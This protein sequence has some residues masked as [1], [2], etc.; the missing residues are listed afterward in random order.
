MLSA[1]P[2]RCNQVPVRRKRGILHRHRSTSRRLYQ[3]R[4]EMRHGRY[5][6][7]GQLRWCPSR[8]CRERVSMRVCRRQV[9]LRDDQPRQRRVYLRRCGGGRRRKPL[10]CATDSPEVAGN[11]CRMPRFAMLDQLDSVPWASLP[12][13]K[14]NRPAA[15]PDA[16]RRLAAPTSREDARQAY[17]ARPRKVVI[18]RENGGGAAVGA[19]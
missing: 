5:R 8:V 7:P 17:N 18:V 12:Q 2:V 14:W 4:R 9:E 3:R 19:T 13:P 10:T 11:A 6:S 16:I 15:V 1:R